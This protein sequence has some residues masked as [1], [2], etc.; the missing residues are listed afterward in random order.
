MRR[1]GRV[2]TAVLAGI[3]CAVDDPGDGEA[4]IAPDGRFRLGA[5]AGAWAKP[6]AVYIGF[7]ARAAARARRLAAIAER[8]IQLAGELA[9]LQ[10]AN[11]AAGA[12]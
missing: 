2:V 5:L 6:E 7:A 8:L 9:T 11:G 12:R 1:A 10:A 4:W 3:A